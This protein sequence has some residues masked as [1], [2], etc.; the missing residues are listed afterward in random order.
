MELNEEEAK[1]EGKQMGVIVSQQLSHPNIVK[2]LES[3]HIRIKVC[4]LALPYMLSS[5]SIVNKQSAHLMSLL[6]HD[7]TARI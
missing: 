3:G 6:H 7:L 4:S 1:A 2:A 5:A